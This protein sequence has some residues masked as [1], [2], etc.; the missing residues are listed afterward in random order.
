MPTFKSADPLEQESPGLQ[1]SPVHQL[2]TLSLNEGGTEATA[3]AVKATL[4]ICIV[5]KVDWELCFDRPFFVAMAN[6]AARMLCFA[7]QI[8]S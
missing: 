7:G 5:R 6:R 3:A 4:D 2:P 1:T 8:N